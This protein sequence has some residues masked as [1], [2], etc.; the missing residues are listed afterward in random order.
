[1]G[2]KLGRQEASLILE[3]PSEDMMM[4]LNAALK[5]REKYFGRKVKLCVLQNAKSGACPEDCHYCSQ[6]I[7]SE[8]N[9]EQYGLKTQG[10]IEKGADYAHSIGATR[11]C[12]VL[13]GRGPRDRDI[14]ELVDAVRNI[15]KKYKLEICCSLGLLDVDKAKRLKDAGVGWVNHNINTSER[16][17]SE[18]CTTHSYQ[19]RIDTIKS[20]IEAGLQPCSG[21][22]VG[23]GETEEDILDVIETARELGVASI[24]INFLHAI[25][26]TLFEDCGKVDPVWALKVLCLVRFMIPDK[27]IRAA[28]G[29]EHNLG[30]MQKWAMYPA[31]SLFVDGYLT[32][33]G[34]SYEEALKMITEMGFEVEG[35]SH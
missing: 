5:I 34:Q 29:R 9:V 25:E 23:M 7:I 32:T 4:V 8:A 10:E 31:N 3:A 17:H 33:G 18:I 20:V 26:G 11:Y 2:K 24:P 28:G 19:D 1:M 15:R 14:D 35:V 6:S 12:I 16:F 30:E 21:G 27:E 13:S 22:I